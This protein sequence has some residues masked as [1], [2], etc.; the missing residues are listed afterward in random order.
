ML[1]ADWLPPHSKL[2]S[3]PI[4]SP[5]SDEHT[6]GIRFALSSLSSSSHFLLLAITTHRRVVVVIIIIVAAIT[7]LQAVRQAANTAQHSEILSS[8]KT[9]PKCL[10][11]AE[12]LEVVGWCPTKLKTNP[13]AS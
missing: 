13:R 4:H 6:C 10:A 11:C 8:E 12:I 1:L 5:A 3:Q 9:Q 2:S 7:L